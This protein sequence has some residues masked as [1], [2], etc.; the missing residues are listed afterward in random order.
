MQLRQNLFIKK[1][2]REPRRIGAVAPATFRLAQAISRTTHDIYRSYTTHIGKSAR[3]FRLIELGAGTGALTRTISNLNPLVIESDENW[4]ALLK[5]QFPLLE[6]RNECA[7]DLLRSLNEPVGIV[8]SI[9]M[10]NNPTGRDISN[11][12]AQKYAEGHILFCITYTYGWFDPLRSVGFRRGYRSNFVAANIP[13]ASVW[14]Y[15]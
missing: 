2:L 10:L 1:F 15:L 11:L 14:A 7:T 4:S 5:E 6:I 8:T 12:M 9:P 13:P 3:P